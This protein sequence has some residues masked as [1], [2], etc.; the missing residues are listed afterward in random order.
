MQVLTAAGALSALLIILKPITWSDT[1]K[2]YR[3]WNVEQSYLDQVSYLLHL[4]SRLV[5]GRAPRLFHSRHRQG[6]RSDLLS[7]SSA[8]IRAIDAK[9]AR[10]EKPYSPVMMVSLLLYAYCVGVFSSRRI[11]RATY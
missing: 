2:T 7:S 6:A 9:D 3:P 5:T 11:E 10:G 1:V 4:A 8:I